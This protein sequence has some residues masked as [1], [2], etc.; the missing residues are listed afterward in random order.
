MSNLKAMNQQLEKA[1]SIKEMLQVPFVKERAIK[2]FESMTGRKDGENWF[3]Q[4]AFHV[5]TLFAEKPDLKKA[6]RMSILACF[7]KAG[8]SGLSISQGHLDLIMY[9]NVLKAEVNYH[10]DREQLRRMPEIKF[11]G[12]SVLVYKE[13]KFLF[14]RKKNKVLEHTG[15]IPKVINL[16]TIEA[17][18]ITVEFTDGREVDV[19]MT[20]EELR[21][22]K[23]MSKNKSANGPWETWTGQMCK[24]S[25]LRRAHDLYYRA[26]QRE[27]VG[28]SEVSETEETIETT[29]VDQPEAEQQQNS[30]PINIQSETMEET[31]I[32][33]V[34]KKETKEKKSNM[35]KFLEE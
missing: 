5:M 16:D 10:G 19:M 8:A 6:D 21:K 26:P 27:V 7:V 35:S 1:G 24:K 14:D 4:E 15:G 29:H 12:E 34:D 22:A 2:N 23:S 20:N 9:G 3:Q 11:V 33:V 31:P 30:E 25:V 28:L 13:D 17:A 18:Y 32:E